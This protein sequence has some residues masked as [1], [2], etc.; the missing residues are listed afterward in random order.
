MSQDPELSFPE[1]RIWLARWGSPYAHGVSACRQQHEED[2]LSIRLQYDEKA[3]QEAA[4]EYTP[5]H[6]DG[7]VVGGKTPSTTIAEEYS[8]A[9]LVYVQQT[10]V[11]AYVARRAH[12]C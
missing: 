1:S 5:A 11:C 6:I 10:L 4:K 2:A 7:H 9:D 3:S 8:K 12:T